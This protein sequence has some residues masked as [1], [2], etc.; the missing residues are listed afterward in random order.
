MRGRHKFS[1]HAYVVMPDHA[2]ILVGMFGSSL[3]SLMRDWKRDSALAIAKRRNMPGAIWQAR[4]FD[5]IPRRVGDFWQKME[6]IHRNPLEKQLVNKAEE[7]Q[8]SS[9]AFYAR[10]G[11][12]PIP[13]DQ[14]YLPLDA[15]APL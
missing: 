6:Y 1:L 5:F 8:W 13:V 15:D 10:Q 11:T 2:H 7:W 14:P 4:Y 9:A 3:P 12:A